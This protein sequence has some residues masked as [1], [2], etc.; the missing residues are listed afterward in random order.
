[1]N[2]TSLSPPFK[3]SGQQMT[4]AVEGSLRWV[5]V[6][7]KELEWKIKVAKGKTQAHYQEWLG[8]SAMLGRPC[9]RNMWAWGKREQPEPPSLTSP[10]AT[11]RQEELATPAGHDTPRVFNTGTFSLSQ[12]MLLIVKDKLSSS[13]SSSSG[14]RTT[15]QQ[16]PYMGC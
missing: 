10:Q 4:N 14:L 1:M 2:T 11:P 3:G 6:E 9:K 15:K 13:L 5:E 16:C 7:V 8:T 12:N